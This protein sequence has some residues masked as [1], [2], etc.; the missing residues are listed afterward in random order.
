M[1]IFSGIPAAPGIGIGPAFMA[2]DKPDISSVKFSG[3][4]NEKKRL[5]DAM[6][7]FE[8]ATRKLEEQS[9]AGIMLGQLAM[10]RDPFMSGELIQEIENGAAAEHAVRGVCEKFADMFRSSGDSLMAQRAADV[11]DVGDRI[12]RILMGL[13]SDEL[14]EGAVLAAAEVTPSMTAGLGGRAAAII[15]EKGGATSHGAIL[16]RAL[17][18]PAVMGADFGGKIRAGDTVI[19]DGGEGKIYVNPDK[20]TLSQFRARL[21]EAE[22]EKK[23]LAGFRDAEVYSPEGH[24]VKI[25]AN[26]GSVQEAEAALENG[27]EGV[28]L[29]RTEFLFMDRPAAPTES[30]QER[31]YR[32]ISE[33]FAGKEVI[34]RTLDVGGDKNVPYLGL[35]REENPF[36]GLRGIR[37]CLKNPEI[38]KTQLRAILRAGAGRDNLLIMLPLV[39]APEEIR[40]ARELITQCALELKRE[41]AEF[42]KNTKVGVMIETPAAGLT[43]GRLTEEADFFSIGTNDLTQYT[44][45]VDR[46]NSDV[47]ELYNP[48]HPAVLRQISETVEAAHGRGIPV[49]VCGEAAGQEE[50]IPILIRYGI[51][52][53]SVGAANL[54]RVKK[55]GRTMV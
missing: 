22:A 37:Y 46:G 23:E 55:I 30:E 24:R 12:I 5:E 15:S 48:A 26:I 47:S 28:G 35:K 36:L 19:A 14:P 13:P 11:L 44:L 27:A 4:E 50:L 9:G 42:Q 38:F 41:K 40:E 17:G 53:L 2:G 34:I 25:Y 8:A 6:E 49:G 32:K 43:S 18:I 7:K 54:L 1:E 39:T 3:A 21:R 10:A 29:F 20:E 31:I 45:A 52:E 51:D 33:L 16:A